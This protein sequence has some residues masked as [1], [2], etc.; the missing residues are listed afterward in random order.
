MYTSSNRRTKSRTK[1]THRTK[2]R[3]KRT[4]GRTLRQTPSKI[5]D[6]HVELPH[7]ILED[8]LDIKEHMDLLKSIGKRIK[9][10]NYIYGRYTMFIYIYLI[11]K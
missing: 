7:P 2:S 3:T 4:K 11:K 6:E 5:V 1:S 10:P 9:N 8:H